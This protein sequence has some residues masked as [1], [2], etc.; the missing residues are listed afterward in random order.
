MPSVFA[1]DPAVRWEQHGEH[2]AR[3][4]IPFEEGEDELIMAFCPE[5][6]L[7]E[8]FSARRYRG[9]EIHKTGWKINF[10]DWRRFGPVLIPIRCSVRWEDE[11]G[12]WLHLTVD[13][14]HYN[15][16]VSSVI[17]PHN[18]AK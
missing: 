5:S 17:P 8:G 11:R 10:G 16:D 2:T 18:P 6:G 1:L 12:P 3:L 7:P 14:V 9:Q 15:E 4:V 13:D